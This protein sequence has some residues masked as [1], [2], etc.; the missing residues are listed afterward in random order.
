VD[1]A[2]KIDIH[3]VWDFRVKFPGCEALKVGIYDYDLAFGD[4]LI[5]ETEI[6]LET[7]YFSADWNSVSVKPI[8]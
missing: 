8:E 7:R 1:D 2:N 5:G 4:D 6:D 3:K